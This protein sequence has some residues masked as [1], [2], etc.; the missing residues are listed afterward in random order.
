MLDPSII[1]TKN[2]NL[3]NQETVISMEFEKSNLHNSDLKELLIKKKNELLEPVNY[4][5]IYILKKIKR[6]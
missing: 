6:K 2:F 3:N 5:F 1:G 4:F